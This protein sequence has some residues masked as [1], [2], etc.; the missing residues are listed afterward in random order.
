MMMENCLILKELRSEFEVSKGS[1]KSPTQKL[2]LSEEM[3]NRNTLKHRN[4]GIVFFEEEKFIQKFSESSNGITSKLAKLEAEP[5]GETLFRKV[6]QDSYAK[7]GKLLEKVEKNFFHKSVALRDLAYFDGKKCIKFSR[8][9]IFIEQLSRYK[10]GNFLRSELRE[11]A[12]NFTS[13]KSL[14]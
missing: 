6:Y 8:G 1:Y 9:V 2:N 5:T 7:A 14:K 13:F 4:R 12:K 10:T 11:T 3:M